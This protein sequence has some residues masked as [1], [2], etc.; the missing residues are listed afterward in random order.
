MWQR[1]PLEGGQW[2]GVGLLPYICPFSPYP[3]PFAA[4]SVLHGSHA[5]EA[6]AV[7]RMEKG[8]NAIAF[9]PFCVFRLSE[10]IFLGVEHSGGMVVIDILHAQQLEGFEQHLAHL[11][12]GDRAVVRVAFLH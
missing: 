5:E 9:P 12:K 11:A 10:G 8:G 1:V 4:C 2:C 7:Q 3:C 6:Q